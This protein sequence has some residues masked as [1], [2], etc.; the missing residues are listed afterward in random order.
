MDIRAVF[1]LQYGTLLYPTKE[2][3]FHVPLVSAHVID[4][5]CE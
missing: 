5:G 2:D 1:P 4:D 3:H